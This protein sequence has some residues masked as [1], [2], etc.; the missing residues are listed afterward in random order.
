MAFGAVSVLKCFQKF[1][2]FFRGRTGTAVFSA[3]AE[4]FSAAPALSAESIRQTDGL[5][6]SLPGHLFA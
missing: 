2:V 1:S 4:V 5:A 3:I 6:A